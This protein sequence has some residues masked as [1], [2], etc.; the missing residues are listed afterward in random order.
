MDQKSYKFS[1][2]LYLLVKDSLNSIYLI[3]NIFMLTAYHLRGG[4]FPWLYKFWLNKFY[5][6]ILLL[7]KT[8]SKLTEL[9]LTGTCLLFGFVLIIC[10]C[11]CCWA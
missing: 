8:P 11:C 2:L 7:V 1:M 6:F 10:C 3:K 4:W 5:I 9:S